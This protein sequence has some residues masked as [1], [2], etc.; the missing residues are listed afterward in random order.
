MQV[1]E[2]E[3]REPRAET[4]QAIYSAILADVLSI[5]VRTFERDAQD[6][7]ESETHTVEHPVR[8]SRSS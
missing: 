4:V 6:Y 8:K 1:S 7:I 3:L 2:Q 5:D